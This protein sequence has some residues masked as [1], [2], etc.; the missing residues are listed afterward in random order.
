MQIVVKSGKV[1][2][3]HDISIDLRG[4]YAGAE[5]VR[6]TES[7][8]RKCIPAS[9]EREI[10]GHKIREVEY[11]SDPRG[12]AAYTLDDVRAQRDALLSASDYTQLPDMP[13]STEIRAAWASYRQAL[14]DLPGTY[15]DA[16]EIAWP[17]AP[18]A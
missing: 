13:L 10:S 9:V 4:K 17:V 5:V 11:K 18:G 15:A 6:V 3:V 2:A 7:L 1:I 14:R 8:G 16:S 12:T